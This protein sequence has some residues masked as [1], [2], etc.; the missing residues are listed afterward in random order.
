MFHEYSIFF[1]TFNLSLLSKGTIA[2]NP[3]CLLH[4]FLKYLISC[5]YAW[6]I[7]VFIYIYATDKYMNSLYSKKCW[8]SSLIKKRHIYNITTLQLYKLWAWLARIGPL[9]KNQEF[10]LWWWLQCRSYHVSLPIYRIPIQYLKWT[11]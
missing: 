9:T 6:W 11:A 3:F 1:P 5:F 8:K 10:A 7:K 2:I 4:D